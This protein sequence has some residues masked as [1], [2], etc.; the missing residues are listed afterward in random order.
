MT[1]ALEFLLSVLL[2]V[3]A[4]A[5]VFTRDLFGLTVLL[6]VYSGLIGVV[7]A[8]LCA[9]DVAFTEAVV[10]AGLSTGLLLAL[11]R[12]LRADVN[13]VTLN[14]RGGQR[15]RRARKYA[16]SGV[17]ASV[18]VVLLYA[19]HALPEFGSPT[20]PAHQRVAAQ[21]LERTFEDA[22]TP[23]AVTT[24]LGDYRSFDTMIEASV[25]L[26]GAVACVL[27]LRKAKAPTREAR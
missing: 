17:A 21:Y 6:S 5:L 16:A 27:I 8:L 15:A 3:T 13:W 10:G 20:S 7:L 25:V 12:Y 18:G 2:T 26:T 11:L 1:D 23:N 22:K 4:V 19:V 14:A 24:V 9:V